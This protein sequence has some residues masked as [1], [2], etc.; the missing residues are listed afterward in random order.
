[1]GKKRNIY[2]KDNRK[3]VFLRNYLALK[4]DTKELYSIYT[5][6]KCNYTKNLKAKNKN[7]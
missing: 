1:M 5:N 4:K 2:C 3:Q 7:T 6:F